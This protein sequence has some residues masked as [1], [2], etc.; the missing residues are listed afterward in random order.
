M[1]LTTTAVIEAPRKVAMKLLRVILNRAASVPPYLSGRL[2][3]ARSGFY[4]CSNV[5]VCRGARLRATDGAVGRLSAGVAIDRF[6][7]LTVQR[8]SLKIGPR[9]YVGQFTVISAIESISIGADCLI[10]E[11]VSIR[12]QDHRFGNGL[13]VR[14]AGF[15]SAPIVVEDNVWIGAK[16]TITKGVTVGEN[17]VVGANSVVTRNVPPNAV[18]AGAPARVLR[19][20]GR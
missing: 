9:T 1:K 12:D 6:A 2:A 5:R 4:W 13:M 11:H 15:I 3:L 7:D 14:S 8:G 17:S 19:R 16:V 18:V 20:I 10:A